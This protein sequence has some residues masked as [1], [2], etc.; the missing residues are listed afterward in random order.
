ML[1]IGAL[2]L[3]V[4]FLLFLYV[5][6]RRL[7]RS[8]QTFTQQTPAIVPRR[9]APKQKPVVQQRK[10]RQNAKRKK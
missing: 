3:F 2:V 7:T 8:S 4:L 9:A 5:R 1:I 6:H 10:P